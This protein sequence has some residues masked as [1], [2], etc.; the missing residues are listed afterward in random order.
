M[1]LMAKRQVDQGAKARPTEISDG[2][3]LEGTGWGP[4]EHPQGQRPLSPG[5]PLFCLT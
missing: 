2:L 5:L 4:P 1:G 3:H